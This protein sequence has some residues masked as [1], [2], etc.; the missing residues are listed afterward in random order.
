MIFF[1]QISSKQLAMFCRRVGTSIQAGIDVRSTIERESK[2]GSKA[3]KT[4]MVRIRHKIK[5]GESLTDAMEAEG[6]YFPSQFH[7]M[8]EVG[9]KTGRLDL[10]LTRM[11]EYYEQ[12]SSLKRVFFVSILWPCIQLA[13]ALGVVGLLIWIMGWISSNPKE[14]VDLLGF[15][16]IGN[17]GLLIYVLFLNVVAFSVVAFVSAVRR[18]FLLAPISN[19][20]MRIPGVGPALRMMAQL[21]FARTL[22]L[23]IDAGLDAVNSTDLAF[24]STQSPFFQRFADTVKR[25]VRS[26]DE[27]H[28]CLART[29]VFNQHLVDAVQ[30]GEESGRLA[31][32][33]ESHASQMDGQV[34]VA[35]QSLTFFAAMAVW[36][37]VG[38]FIIFLIFRLASFYLGILN[39][40]MNF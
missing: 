26:G 21:R 37:M 10:V 7:R 20:L 31:E 28:L 16:L 35:F 4:R 2:T 14:Q 17:R 34:K 33:L 32:S 11:A 23:A 5:K 38:A 22:G 9:E 25:E 30:V 36:V 13:V 8:V 29:G 40:A 24:K 19:L 18:G 6:N 1:P 27:I 39:D 12:I 3:Y 15:G